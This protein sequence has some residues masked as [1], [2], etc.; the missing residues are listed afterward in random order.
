[1]ERE[2]SSVGDL[3]DAIKQAFE[4]KSSNIKLTYLDEDSEQLDIVSS[5][6]LRAAIEN[7]L[8]RNINLKIKAEETGEVQ[9]EEIESEGEQPSEPLH[10]MDQLKESIMEL[11]LDDEPIIHEE[12]P[13]ESQ[14]PQEEIKEEPKEPLRD[15]KFA[16]LFAKVE[17]VINQKQDACP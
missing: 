3:K 1:L 11:R 13:Q 6:D 9:I 8:K 7:S 16:E 14:E 15:F 4:L 5:E 12:F 10:F 2:Y 17:E